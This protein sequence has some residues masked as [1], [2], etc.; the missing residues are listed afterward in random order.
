M[1]SRAETPFEAFEMARD[2]LN[3]LGVTLDQSTFL[4]YM[5]EGKSNW[6]LAQDAGIERERIFAAAG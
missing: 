2:A 6:D 5:Q 4:N 1:P 3:E